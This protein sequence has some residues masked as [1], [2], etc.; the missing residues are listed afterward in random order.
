MAID[1]DNEPLKSQPRV[2]I[3][4]WSVTTR[5]SEKEAHCHF[6]GGT[7]ETSKCEFSN[8]LLVRVVAYFQILHLYFSLNKEDGLSSKSC[9]LIG[10]I[11]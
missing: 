5:C 6:L 4:V 8:H 3:F 1:I 9:M 10:D 2:T 7:F 11:N